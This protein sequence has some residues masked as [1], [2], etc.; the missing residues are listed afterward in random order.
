[1]KPNTSL[2]AHFWAADSKNTGC[3]A[4]AR[5]TFVRHTCIF[6]SN[7]NLQGDRVLL[8]LLISQN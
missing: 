7:N 3:F 1:M 8:Y 6:A 2:Y 4:R 5:H